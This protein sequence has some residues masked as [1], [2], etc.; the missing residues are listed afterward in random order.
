[1]KHKAQSSTILVGVISCCVKAY[2]LCFISYII[3]VER[4]H[5]YDYSK[6]NYNVP[7]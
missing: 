3:K 7:I 1:M 2:V 4:F 6:Y 5:K